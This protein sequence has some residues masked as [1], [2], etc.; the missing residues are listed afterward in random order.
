[1][2]STLPVSQSH[3]AVAGASVAKGRG[4]ISL[5]PDGLSR[6]RPR[7]VVYSAEKATTGGY[8]NSAS[9]TATWT[10]ASFPAVSPSGQALGG[11]L[12]VTGVAGQNGYF[13]SFPFAAGSAGS[14]PT[15]LGLKQFA[16]ASGQV[17]YALV[18]VEGTDYQLNTSFSDVVQVRFEKDGS[19]YV[20]WF[21]PSGSFQL[22]PG[23]NFLIMRWDETSSALGR[24]PL[25]T[26][27]IADGSLITRVMIGCQLGSTALNIYVAEVGYWS[28][29]PAKPMIALTFD[30]YDATH[31]NLVMPLLQAKGIKG[32]FTTGAGYNYNDPTVPD[33]LVAGGMEVGHQ[34]YRHINYP[35]SGDA[36][37]TAELDNAIA[38]SKA[39]GY[40]WEC[41]SMPYNDITK[42]QVS[43]AGGK[44]IRIIRESRQPITPI[45]E[46]GFGAGKVN[47]CYNVGQYGLDNIT[48]ANMK[49]A[50]AAAVRYG[51]LVVTTAHQALSGGTGPSGSSTQFYI[52][53]LAAVIDDALAQGCTFVTLSE[54]VRSLDA[55]AAVTV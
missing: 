24:I 53:D 17:L 26:G 51:A 6:V 36:I 16:K 8:M 19:N 27:S 29:P 54:V 48:L 46:W 23:W 55:L 10:D 11:K 25:V 13:R 3:G 50:A 7:K 35:Q 32:T 4:F 33:A 52:D 21:F 40:S 38:F 1:M 30:G 34:V 15:T 44:G 28:A 31:V 43:I 42:S 20:D 45:C 12:T 22:K 2:V 9:G 14:L 47:G 5:A 49:L 18:Y 39:L 41:Q 37:Y